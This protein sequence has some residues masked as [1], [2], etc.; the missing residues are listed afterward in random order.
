MALA[1]T[2]LEIK[3]LIENSRDKDYI[4]ITPENKDVPLRS[5]TPIQVQHK[6][7]EILDTKFQSFL[8]ESKGRCVKCFPIQHCRSRSQI[9]TLQEFSERLE[10]KFPGEF[11]KIEDFVHGST[12]CFL[13][14]KC[15]TRFETKQPRDL[16]RANTKT[17]G[18][19]QCANV[20]RGNYISSD[21]YLDDIIVD[22]YRWLEVYKGN[23][24]ALHK[25]VHETCGHIYNVRPNDFQQ[26]YRCP[27]C[28]NG[29]LPLVSRN[30]KRL[31]E[32]LEE[33]EIPFKTEYIDKH[34][35]S[36]VGGQLVFDFVLEHLD[37]KLLVIEYDGELH[38]SP[39]QIANGIVLTKN[40]TNVEKLIHTQ[41]RRDRDKDTYVLHH[42]EKYV[43][44]IRIRYDTP[45][46]ESLYEALQ[47]YYE[48]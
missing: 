28:S 46:R 2:Y 42:P 20:V 34:C 36:S 22:G 35:K 47:E 3:T 32:Y 24:K 14:H 19:Q 8:N 33:L 44:I 9:L 10:I 18:C 15:G 1:K 5:R 38:G 27:E 25:I 6:C 11:V 29:V 12:S 13:T 41:M 7:G 21:T 31:Q 17:H 26:G 43:G 37:G 16:L 23:N 45:L 40:S 4:L 30:A 48:F 39:E